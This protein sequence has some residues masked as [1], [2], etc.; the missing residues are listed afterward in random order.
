MSEEN[1]RN[2]K[3]VQKIIQQ[4]TE[5][6]EKIPELEGRNRK[7]NLQFMVTRKK[8]RVQNQTLEESK[9]KVKKEKEGP[10]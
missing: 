3:E 1:Y 2:N 8:S 4:D 5:M 10:S 9:I 7:N 6:N